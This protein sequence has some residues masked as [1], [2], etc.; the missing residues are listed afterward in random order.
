[1]NKEHFIIELKLHLRPLSQSDRDKIINYY[2]DYFAKEQA[3]GLSEYEISRTLP[4]PKEIAYGIL[5]DYDIPVNTTEP[6]QNDWVE[7]FVESKPSEEVPE[8]LYTEPESPFVRLFQ[9]L[10]IIA[11]NTFFMIWLI[12]VFVCLLVAGWLTAIVLI[13]SPGLT[14]YNLT[15]FISTFN[16]FQ[17]SVSLALC[18]VGLIGFLLLRPLTA[19]GYKLLKAYIKWNLQIIRGRRL[20]R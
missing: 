2:L 3:N 11:L 12:L 7:F 16:L 10:G 13:A 1:M 8:Y 20:V 5:E 17:F 4:H 9:I 6:A 15:H 19:G 18:G 14:V